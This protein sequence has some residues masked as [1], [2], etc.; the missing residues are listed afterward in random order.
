MKILAM[1]VFK[2]WLDSYGR[3]SKENN[4]QVSAELFAQD[5]K[6]FETPFEDFENKLLIDMSPFPRG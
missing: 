2:H 5:A 1:D 4:A 3:A 6:Y